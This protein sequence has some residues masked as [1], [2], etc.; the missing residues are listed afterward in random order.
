MAERLFVLFTREEGQA[1][2][3][4]APRSPAERR[5]AVALVARIRSAVEQPPSADA[6]DPHADDPGTPS[7]RGPAR[8]H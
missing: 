5:L 7:P 8:V 2:A 3:M 1:L 4:L 6:V